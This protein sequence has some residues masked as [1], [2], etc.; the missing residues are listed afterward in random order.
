MRAFR[1]LSLGSFALVLSLG[2]FFILPG[3]DDGAK[4]DGTVA[5]DAPPLTTDQKAVF[6][7]AYKQA[8]AKGATK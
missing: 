3:C 6:D 2:S 1:S 5:K 4:T 8:P 7:N